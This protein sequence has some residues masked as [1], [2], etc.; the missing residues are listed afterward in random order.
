MQINQLS[1]NFTLKEMLANNHGIVQLVNNYQYMNLKILCNRV[2]QPAR[3]KLNIPIVINSG[4]RNIHLNKIVGGVLNSQHCT[5]QAVDVTCADMVALFNYIRFHLQYDQTIIYVNE[6]N[7]AMFIHVSYNEGKNRNE[8][9][10]CKKI[11]SKKTYVK[12]NN[13]I[14]TFIRW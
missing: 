12:I 4:Y 7:R 11:G 9:L 5:G 2:L 14:L 13:E 3:D 8:D 1:K 6:N 10:I